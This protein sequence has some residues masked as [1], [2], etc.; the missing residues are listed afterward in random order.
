MPNSII[1]KGQAGLGN[2]ILCLLTCIL[3]AKLSNRTLFVDWRDEAYSDNKLNI[4]PHLFVNESTLTTSEYEGSNSIKPKIWDDCLDLSVLDLCRHHNIAIT[5]T[6]GPSVYKKYSISL[7]NI[8]YNDE[9]VVFSSYTH[10]LQQLRKHFTGEF[11][12]YSGLSNTAILSKLMQEELKP[13]DEVRIKVEDFVKRH[14]NAQTIGV[15][16]RYTDRSTP[17][18]KFHS[19]IKK[20]RKN[21]KNSQIF[22]ACDNQIVQKDFESRYENIITTDKWLPEPGE[23][24]HYNPNKP[25]DL[26]VAIDALV[27]MHLLSKCDYLIYPSRS[28]FSYI[29]H[30]LSGLPDENV[31]DIDKWNYIV[32]LKHALHTLA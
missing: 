10:K 25:N 20:I 16:I 12:E 3:Y 24:I 5:K 4:F 13:A 18:D 26:D 27:D 2:R 8:Q 15:H 28:T 32:K 9:V 19:A 17:L 22:L 23:R 21:I 29:S 7:K 30:L 6:N 31:I 14:F 1:C 11:A